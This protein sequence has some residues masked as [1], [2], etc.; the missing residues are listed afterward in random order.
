[1][2][3]IEAMTTQRLFQSLLATFRQHE[4]GVAPWNV[5]CALSDDEL[6][7]HFRECG[8]L[9]EECPT[10]SYEHH[11]GGGVMRG[12]FSQEIARRR[13]CREFPALFGPA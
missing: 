4:A 2:A 3:N 11:V 5:I 1:M 6:D 10:D 8:R 9:Y 7:A 13:N 12:W